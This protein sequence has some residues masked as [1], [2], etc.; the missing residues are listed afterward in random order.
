[1]FPADSLPEEGCSN[2]ISATDSQPGS[3]LSRMA[4][5]SSGLL[6][7]TLTT[8]ILT[9]C[10][11]GQSSIVISQIYGGGG[12][13]GATLRNDYVELFNRG[14]TAV[15]MNGWTVQ[16]TSAAGS[17]WDRVPLSGTIQPGQYFLLQ[18]AQG[19]AGTA[20]LPTPDATSG[21][22]ISATSAKIVL[23]NNSVALTGSVP[24]G[25]QILDF[26][27]YG[28]ANTTEGRSAPE[29]TNTTALFRRSGGC[30]DTGDNRA[31]FITG[32]PAPRNSRTQP[33][34]CFVD[35][36]PLISAAGVANAASFE[37]GFIA[38][39]QV[40]TI[41]GS[42]MGGDE[43]ATLE[44]TADRQSIT[45]SLSGT[46]VLFD[47]VPAPMIYA[48]SGQVSA[49]VP[50]GI[51]SRRSVE[52]QVEY[53]G[54]LSNKVPLEVQP[55]APGIFTM[56]SSGTGAGAILNQDYRPNGLDNPAAKGSVIILFATGGGVTSPES[57]DGRIA[58]GIASQTQ[59][60]RLRID[61]VEAE[62][63]YAGSAP[64]L[65]SGV[66]QINAKVPQNVGTGW[67][68]IEVIAGARTSRSGVRVAVAAE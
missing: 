2:K 54:R 24:T 30:T 5:V 28:T 10:A 9:V 46:R 29:L 3:P 17:T 32:P 42:A 62:I 27:G 40:V 58:V 22:N 68:S 26:V 37:S 18:L 35:A 12:N 33:S 53:S 67:Q 57:T 19:N 43:L 25:S 6:K 20:A 7:L 41:F 52:L 23:V 11:L 1:M 48:L 59:P 15:F 16:H 38:P 34:P 55:T 63:L 47:G 13:S 21:V 66:M 50:F 14:R 56:D 65:V 39:G 64:G 4:K 45:K 36:S 31:D 51:A 61:G 8:T 49:I 60:I 44:L